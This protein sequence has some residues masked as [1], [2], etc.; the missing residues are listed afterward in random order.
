M[1]AGRVIAQ[2][3]A[4]GFAL[5]C[6]VMGRLRQADLPELQPPSWDLMALYWMV[7]FLFLR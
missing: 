6:L 4:L 3:I 1:N 5:Y 7:F 2:V